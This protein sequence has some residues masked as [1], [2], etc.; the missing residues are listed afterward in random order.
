MLSISNNML[1]IW[2]IFDFFVHV[3]FE[4]STMS[5]LSDHNM[6]QM[7]FFCGVIE[8]SIHSFKAFPDQLP[9]KVGTF[10]LI[11]LVSFPSIVCL[12]DVAMTTGLQAPVDGP[13]H[14]WLRWRGN[15][16][17]RVLWCWIHSVNQLSAMIH[18]CLSGHQF[19]S[20][21]CAN[22][23]MPLCLVSVCHMN[24]LAV[25]YILFCAAEL[26]FELLRI[27]LLAHIKSRN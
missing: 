23:K 19:K 18:P 16:G 5:F 21:K 14:Y 25:F 2:H 24:K 12:C 3:T 1:H 17:G 11:T 9:P 20:I 8:V 22:D 26:N 4:S 15:T 27:D 10:H 7:C 13:Y 6:P